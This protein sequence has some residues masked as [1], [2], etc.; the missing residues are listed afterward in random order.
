MGTPLRFGPVKE[1]SETMKRMLRNK[2]LLKDEYWLFVFKPYLSIRIND[3]YQVAKLSPGQPYQ[4]IVRGILSGNTWLDE[5]VAFKE[6]YVFIV[7]PTQ[8]VS[9]DPKDIAQCEANRNNLRVAN[10]KSPLVC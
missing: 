9:S 1:L 8:R 7:E 3:E 2:D 5:A 4:F 10:K 6:L